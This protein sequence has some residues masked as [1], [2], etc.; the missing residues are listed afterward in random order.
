MTADPLAD[1]WERWYRSNPVHWK[2]SLLPL[3]RLREGARVLDVGCGD[4]STLIQAAEAGYVP[5]GIDLSKTALERAR[6]RVEARGFDVR[7]ME[8]NILEKAELLG[9][10]DCILLHH[11]LDSMLEDNRR[12]VVSIAGKMLEKDGLV[13][14]Q[15][16]SVNDMRSGKGKEIEAGTFLRKDGLFVHFFTM[17][18]VSDLFRGFRVLELKET[19]WEQS[20]GR[21][22]MVRSRIGGLFQPL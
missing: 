4:G 16:Y 19:Q 13:S 22:S 7:L 10:F 20:R 18:E 11:V 17:E 5:S 6:E 12:K 1:A 9:K 3:P 21:G 14:F 2:G 8:G 15:D